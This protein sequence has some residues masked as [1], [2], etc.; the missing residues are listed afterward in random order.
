[1]ADA[2]PLIRLEPGG[3]APVLSYNLPEPTVYT[4]RNFIELPYED[5]VF[6]PDAEDAAEVFRVTLART[7]DH[8]IRVIKVVRSLTGLGLE[9]TKKLVESSRPVILREVTR[10]EAHEARDKLAAAGATAQVSRPRARARQEI[11]EA[12]SHEEVVAEVRQALRSGFADREVFPSAH[13]ASGS[14]RLLEATGDGPA[15]IVSTLRT[16]SQLTKLDAEEI[17]SRKEH[18]EELVLYRSM[19]GQTRYRYAR[20][21]RERP[22]IL[23]VETYRLATYLGAYGAGP[24]IQTFSLLPGERT[25]IDIRTYRKTEEERAETSS[26]LDSFN[27]ESATDFEE[28]IANEQSDRAGYEESFRYNAQAEASASWGWGRASASGGVKGGTNATREQAAKNTTS[29]TN[30]HAQK[31]SAKRRVEVETSRERREVTEQERTTARQIENINVSRTLNFVFRQMNQQY[32]TVLSLVDVRVAFFDGSAGSRDEVTLAELDGLLERHVVE[33]ERD[34]VRAD[35]EEALRNIV[36]FAGV[37]QRD[38]VEERKVDDERYLRVRSEKTSTYAD[39]AND[40]TI[41]VPGIILSATQNVMRTDGVIVEALLGVGGALDG[42]SSRLQDLEIDQR[43]AGARKDQ[44][45]ADREALANAAV[46]DNDAQRAA[47][48]KEIGNACRREAALEIAIR[49]RDG[50]DHEPAK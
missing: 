35:I 43:A 22:R 30:K 41:D 34:R 17:A 40:T 32:I 14:L 10:A 36:D 26:I 3:R 25:K 28:T 15:R 50:T 11:Q 7:G 16:S 47:V 2:E 5:D 38:F 49:Q 9:E 19:A 1:M 6:A 12:P 27:E 18:G 45:L 37:V 8:K 21:R 33:D 13:V 23:L 20:S 46:R 24:V 42:Y 39:E 31:A 4:G 29:A 44:A 48:L